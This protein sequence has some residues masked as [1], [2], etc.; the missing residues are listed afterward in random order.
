[1]GF[2][3]ALIIILSRELNAIF[4]RADLVATVKW[5]IHNSLA[6]TVFVFA[7]VHF[8]GHFH[9]VRGAKSGEFIGCLPLL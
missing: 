7:I 2:L 5:V 3:I 8:A 9:L 1:M 4:G 6:L